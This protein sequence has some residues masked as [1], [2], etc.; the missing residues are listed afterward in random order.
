[1]AYPEPRAFDDFDLKLDRI[2]S[3]VPSLR[4]SRRVG[5]PQLK[6]IQKGWASPPAPAYSSGLSVL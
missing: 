5:Q 1:M 3:E 2:E 4:K 6:F